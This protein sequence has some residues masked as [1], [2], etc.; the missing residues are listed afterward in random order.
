MDAVPSSL[1]LCM[2]SLQVFAQAIVVPD[3]ALPASATHKQVPPPVD[4]HRPSVNFDTPLGIFDGQSDI[5]GPLLPGSGSYDSSTQTYTL[6]SASYNIWYTRDEM[7]FAWKKMS[8]DVSLAADITFP[9]PS[10]PIDRKV[11]LVIRQDLDDGSKEVMAGLH[12]S[13]LIHLAYRP[14]KNAN[15]KEAYKIGSSAK[16]VG[17]LGLW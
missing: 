10:A 4:F 13:G 5:G 8:G 6:N 1:L 16:S 11:V 7:R 2:T 17:E 15:M 9:I 12:A 14:D 3:W